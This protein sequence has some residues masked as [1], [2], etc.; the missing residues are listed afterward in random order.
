MIRKIVPYLFFTAFLLVH[1]TVNAQVHIVSGT[2]VY[3]HSGASV[4][5]KGDFTT[6]SN[7]TGPGKVI[8]KG[9]TVQHCNTNGLSLNNLEIDNAAG[10]ELDT[11]L[12]INN[13]LEFSNGKIKV[14]NHAL[15]LGTTASSTGQGNGKFIETNGT[16]YVQKNIGSNLS[17]FLL[18]VGNEN[19]YNPL[20]ITAAGTFSNAFVTVQSKDIAHPSKHIRSTDFLKHYWHINQTGIT[21]TLNANGNYNDVNSITGDESFLRGI[22]WNGT[23]WSLTGSN[24]NTTTNEAGATI[25]GNGDLY[26]MNKFILSKPKMF[27]Q[28]AY[29]TATSL[30]DDKLRNPGSYNPGSFPSGNLLPVNDPYRNAPFNSSFTHIN[31][32]VAESI[33]NNILN[34]QAD[35]AKNIVDWVFLE[36]RNNDLASPGA[37]V[38]QTR[39]AL[40]RRNGE[41]VDVDGLSPVY[42]KNVDANNNYTL[43]VRHRNHLGIATDP[44]ANLQTIDLTGNSETDFTLMNDA[45]LF[46]NAS[47]FAVNTGKTLLWA[48][49]INAN[50]NIRYNGPANDRDYLLSTILSGN[51]G[52][53]LT[54]VYSNGDINMNRVV[55]YNGPAN[56]RDYLLATPLTNNQGTI[57][58]ES[59][60]Q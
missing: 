32:P 13:Q 54:D 26:A 56:D 5:I 46:G 44:V 1:T 59:L 36:L 14:N 50:N 41:I 9:T 58:T 16:G 3:L 42:F 34:D 15:I 47:A 17:D 49:N 37:N 40:L 19:A 6:N 30:M 39:A 2:Q 23:A 31:N 43:V 7:I 28:G 57:R 55:R 52:T 25:A 12:L 8:L 60:P 48:G 11:D 29:N 21:G 27:L 20:K 33:V 38:V 10:V 22:F 53:I 24:I 18:P 4:V 45:Q 35:A 51:Q